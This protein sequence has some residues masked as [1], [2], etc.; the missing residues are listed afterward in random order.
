VDLIQR[1]RNTFD[2]LVGNYYK[3]YKSMSARDAKEKLVKLQN[4]LPATL[5]RDY[6]VLMAP[7]PVSR[8]LQGCL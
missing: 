6:L 8:M 4:E 5:I 1:Q 2:K 7:A 3:M